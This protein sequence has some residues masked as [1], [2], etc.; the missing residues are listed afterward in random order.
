[1][2]RVVMVA[3]RA[4][5]D[6]GPGRQAVERRAHPGITGLLGVVRF[7]HVVGLG[8]ADL[9]CRGSGSPAARARM[10]PTE[11][12]TWTLA[13]TDGT[14]DVGVTPTSRVTSVM[15]SRSGGMATH[16]PFRVDLSRTSVRRGV[17][18][19]ADR[20]RWMIMIRPDRDFSPDPRDP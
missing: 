12:S 9:A 19:S 16:S 17:P 1:V 4:A 14:R 3:Q 7:S 8:H 18:R 20:L 13:G 2:V 5:D 6:D 10:T 15:V 11:L